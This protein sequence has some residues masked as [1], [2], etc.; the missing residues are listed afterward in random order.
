MRTTFNQKQSQL[1]IFLGTPP[2][3][4]LRPIDRSFFLPDGGDVGCM[5]RS[6]AKLQVEGRVRDL[7]LFNLAID[8]KPR[9]CE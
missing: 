1:S 5:A 6:G 2:L 7:A 4:E 8:R 9:G 3:R